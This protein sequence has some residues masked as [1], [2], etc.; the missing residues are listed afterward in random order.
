MPAEYK[1]PKIDTASHKP[2]SRTIHEHYNKEEYVKRRVYFLSTCEGFKTWRTG[3]FDIAES[4]AALVFTSK[5][6]SK[7]VQEVERREEHFGICPSLPLPTTQN[8]QT[9][10]DFRV[11][12]LEQW[13]AGSA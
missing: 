6:R 7:S 11:Y 5:D 13:Q 3:L 1:P 10:D 9:L 8:C 4:D 12:G 2:G